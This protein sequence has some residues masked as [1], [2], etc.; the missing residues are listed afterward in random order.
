MKIA[1]L[2][3]LV[4][5]AVCVLPHAAFAYYSPSTGRFLNRDPIAEPGAI[6]LRYATI[7]RDERPA[8]AQHEFAPRDGL[9]LP[10]GAN[11]YAYV[12]NKVTGFIDPLGLDE[13]PANQCTLNGSPV[14]WK[15]DG[16]NLEGWEAVS[17]KPISETETHRQL[18]DETVIIYYDLVF[19]YSVARQKLANTGPIPV[20]SY[21]FDVCKGRD[22]WSSPFSHGVKKV[23]WGNYSWS[24]NAHAGTT[25]YGRSGFFIHGGQRWGSAGCIDTRYND[26]AVH[27]EVEKIKKANNCACCYITV[28]VSYPNQFV[29]K[30]EIG[31][32]GRVKRRAPY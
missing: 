23:G 31:Y 9:S 28:D 16:A 10:G 18:F 12:R 24:L 27:D 4:L 8:R 1:R 2:F 25:T 7:P 20:G 11:T 17:G 13:R 30:Q 15:F 22:F 5:L 19:D 21:W 32:G 29:T 6:L 3:A 26:G 14:T